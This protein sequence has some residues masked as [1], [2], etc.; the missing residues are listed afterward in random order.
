MHSGKNC[1]PMHG[2][3]KLA[4]NSKSS[5]LNFN[6]LWL[7]KLCCQLEKWATLIF[8][9]R[10][11]YCISCRQAKGEGELDLIDYTRRWELY[12]EKSSRY[13]YYNASTQKTVWHRPKKADIVSLAKLQSAKKETLREKG[14][15]H[16]R[17]RFVIAFS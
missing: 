1:F 5:K 17:N 13:Y 16:A 11:H 10:T 15:Y 12:D 9:S 6:P 2:K 8:L 4:L 7:F 3:Q 14:E